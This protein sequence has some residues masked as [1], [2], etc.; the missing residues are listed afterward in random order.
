VKSEAN[1]GVQGSVEMVNFAE[2]GIPEGGAGVPGFAGAGPAAAGTAKVLIDA[3][4]NNATEPSGSVP[5]GTK[6]GGGGEEVRPVRRWPV[7]WKETRLPSGGNPGAYLHLDVKLGDQAGLELVHFC[8]A[9][10]YSPA[11]QGALDSVDISIDTRMTPESSGR[12]ANANICPVIVQDGTAHVADWQMATYSDQNRGWV[13]LDFVDLSPHAFNRGAR[14]RSPRPLE[15][16]RPLD[17][18]T[19]GGPMR[20]GFATQHAAFHNNPEGHGFETAIDFDNFVVKVHPA[21]SPR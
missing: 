12:N 19:N 20:F 6:E 14:L 7:T 3:A 21:P 15:Q 1:A 4:V 2:K 17:F 11:I 9:A 13:P 5:G 16:I 10:L 8:Q 18:S